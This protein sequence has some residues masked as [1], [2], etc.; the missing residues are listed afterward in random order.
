M[1]LLY[2]IAARLG[3]LHKCCCRL[4][5]RRGTR[6]SPAWVG[7]YGE[8]AA[9]SWLRARGYC[10][11][12]R[13]FRWGGSGEVDLVCRNGE[14]L[15][16]VEVKTR[17]RTDYGSPGRAVD[18]RK[19]TLLRRGARHWLRLL[20]RE[21]PYRFDIVELVLFDGRRPLVHHRRGAF[22]MRES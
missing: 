9:A 19:R 15:V 21:V 5:P 14:T 1:E 7:R 16:F 18:A 11:L 20:G 4:T 22:S 6:R 12:R 8:E 3:L 10:V 17:T 2:I 13:N